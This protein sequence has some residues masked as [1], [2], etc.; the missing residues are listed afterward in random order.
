MQSPSPPQWLEEDHE[1]EDGQFQGPPNN[2][3]PPATL[4]S[5]PLSLQQ[6]QEDHK[7]SHFQESHQG[8]YPFLPHTF[9]PLQHL[10]QV[11]PQGP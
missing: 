11:S 8:L 3:N 5:L 7:D 2:S 4:Q 1:D 6:Q 10:A 9:H